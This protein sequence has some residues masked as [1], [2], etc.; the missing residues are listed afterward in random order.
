MG[1]TN[2]LNHLFLL[3]IFRAPKEIKQ[4]DLPDELPD[5]PTDVSEIMQTIQN[6]FL[7]SYYGDDL[8]GD[9]EELE[10]K[11]RSNTTEVKIDTPVSSLPAMLGEGLASMVNNP[12]F[13]RMWNA[14]DTEF[15]INVWDELANLLNLHEDFLY[16]RNGV[17]II[18][19]NEGDGLLSLVITAKFLKKSSQGDSAVS[20]DKY[21]VYSSKRESLSE[22]KRICQTWDVT[23]KTFST[24]EELQN[25][26]TEDKYLELHPLFILYDLNYDDKERYEQE[27]KEVG[28]LCQNNSIWLHVN[29][30][31]MGCFAMLDEYKYLTQDPNNVQLF[32]IWLK[33]PYYL[34]S[35]S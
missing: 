2:R 4:L 34:M 27:T 17:G 32:K 1:L 33:L 11:L 15:E 12:K 19:A 14:V 13:A 21:I 29:L 25:L 20:S 31:H 10:A 30:G 28:E 23:L 9:E 7:T 5:E 6:Q 26:V 3:V 35:I 16:N 22:I 24:L 8:E 18:N